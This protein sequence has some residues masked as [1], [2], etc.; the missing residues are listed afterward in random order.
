KTERTTMKTI[1]SLTNADRRNEFSN[2]HGISRRSFLV[3][4]AAGGAALL[5]G[6]LTSLLRAS[7][8]L[9]KNTS[10]ENTPWIEATIPQ[11]QALMATGQLTS[12]DLT[13]GYLNRIA[14]LN[15]LLHAVIE[16]NPNAIAIATGLDNERRKGMV[17]GPLHGIPIL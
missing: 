12:K 11:L 2:S 9:A 16:T 7:S 17:R 8:A 6:G 13:M 10:L 5:T 14:S 1:P 3:T 4:G 15:P